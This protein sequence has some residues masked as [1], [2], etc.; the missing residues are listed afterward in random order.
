MNIGRTVHYQFVVL[1]S[2]ILYGAWTKPLI[3]LSAKI[4]AHMLIFELKRRGRTKERA[5]RILARFSHRKA[6]AQ[7]R[8]TKASFKELMNTI[9]RISEESGIPQWELR[10][11]VQRDFGVDI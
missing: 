7:R 2:K 9:V 8:S 6:S 10:A 5:A 3:R 11:K 1:R 4:Y